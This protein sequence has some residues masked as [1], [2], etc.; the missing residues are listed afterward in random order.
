MGKGSS[1]IVIR[2]MIDIFSELVG[3]LRSLHLKIKIGLRISN[4]ELPIHDNYSK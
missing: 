2:M 1:W 3:V 4:K